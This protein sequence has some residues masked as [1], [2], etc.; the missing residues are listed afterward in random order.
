MDA[1]RGLGETFVHFLHW[2]TFLRWRHVAS[3]HLGASHRANHN[4]LAL[5][6]DMNR[7]NAIVCR[8]RILFVALLA[9]APTAHAALWSEIPSGTTND[10]LAVLEA[11]PE[12]FAV[13]RG[14]YMG[15]P[16][17]TFSAWS[18]V[19]SPTAGDLYSVISQ[20]AGQ[21]WVGSNQGAVH[22]KLASPWAYRPIP[23]S[24]ENFVL[25]SSSSLT[26][27]AAGTGGS[28]YHTSDVGNTWQAQSSGTTYAL[29]AGIESF[30]WAWVVGDHGTILHT[31]N[32]G[33]TW[34]TQ[35]S[36]TTANL[37]GICG[38]GS[39]YMV[40][41]AGGLILRSTNYG[42][43]W[44]AVPSGTGATLRDVGWSLQNGFFAFAVGDGGVVV[45]SSD[46]GQTWC[47]AES[48]GTTQLNAFVALSNSVIIA[49]GNHG[50]IMR[51]DTGVGGCQT[52]GVE[53]TGLGAD[54]ACRI[55]G[56]SP[57]PV[58]G[59]GEFRFAP[60]RDGEVEASLYDASGR[61]VAE[62]F[63]GFVGASESR[64]ASVN[65]A[66]HAPGVY[67]LRVRGE[68]FDVRK[69]VVVAR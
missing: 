46:Q 66:R 63:R 32:N 3:D 11:G 34:S 59:R 47:R 20:S 13:G 53:W 65:A 44:T 14:G 18:P 21:V 23:N 35:S 67:F 30:G 55:A 42:D 1:K 69:R 43:T 33:I 19:A 57:S 58:V 24:L 37:Y 12:L 48:A 28:I 31:K 22:V 29:H 49:V 8:L 7:T 45:K 15:L 56:P 41:G 17:A 61:R 68:G 25:F 4:H 51:T 54:F 27:F 39:T 62:L 9:L 60:A 64:A 50:V 6:P 38:S 10:L 5:E 52:T 36:G 40:V 26:A 16:N 2:R